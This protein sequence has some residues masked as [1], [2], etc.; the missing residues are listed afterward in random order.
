M[1]C[2]AAEKLVKVHTVVTHHP[3][4]WCQGVSGD[5]MQP[6]QVQK[7]KI[8]PEVL[9]GMAAACGN[10]RVETGKEEEEGLWEVEAL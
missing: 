7:K 8:L 10:A 4:R 3:L 2:C 1:V 5:P 6:N 9:K